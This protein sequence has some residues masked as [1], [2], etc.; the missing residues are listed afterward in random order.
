M[1]ALI[2]SFEKLLH[3]HDC[4]QE[5]LLSGQPTPEQW[6][7][8]VEN[9]KKAME[10]YANSQQGEEDTVRLSHEAIEKMKKS[11]LFSPQSGTKG[12]EGV[13]NN[14]VLCGNVV[15]NTV[16]TVCDDCWDKGHNH[17]Q[18]PNEPLTG[19]ISEGLTGGMSEEKIED[20]AHEAAMEVISRDS[21][22]KF[23]QVKHGARAG[24]KIALKSIHLPSEGEIED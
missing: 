19:G 13:K 6:F 1:K 20:L 17:P 23:A 4:E 24:I 10:A 16:F 22:M 15:G 5:G 7:E 14:C 21:W 8:A 3:L 12:A 9:A 2:E 11:K 18:L